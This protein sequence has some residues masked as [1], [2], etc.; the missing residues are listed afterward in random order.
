MNVLILTDL[1]FSILLL[2]VD[3]LCTP[4]FGASGL[5]PSSEESGKLYLWAFCA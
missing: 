5:K 1:E 4:L 3:L 2:R